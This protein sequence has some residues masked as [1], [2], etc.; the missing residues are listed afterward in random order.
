MASV[1]TFKSLSLG[2]NVTILESDDFKEWSTEEIRGYQIDILKEEHRKLKNRREF[3]H[4]KSDYRTVVDRKFD[5]SVESVKDY[6]VVSY[7]R[8]AGMPEILQTAVKL[9]RKVSPRK[10]GQYLSSHIILVNGKELPLHSI[11]QIVLAPDDIVQ[12][13]N[14]TEYARKIEGYDIGTG[15]TTKSGKPR[16]RRPLSSQ[17]PQGVY[18]L[19]ARLLKQ[20]YGNSAYI[21]YAF[22]S[23]D[24]ARLVKVTRGKGKGTKAS[25]RYPMIQIGFSSG[26]KI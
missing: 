8:R 3:P 23:L 11:D 6:G 22:K 1:D 4:K 26:T 21:K 15:G 14:V 9:L 13:M 10:T 5:A 24:S 12:L 20:Q 16:K 7:V 25:N 18:R 2:K 17:A 19:V